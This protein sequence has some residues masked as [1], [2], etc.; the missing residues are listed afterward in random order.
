[1]SHELY[2][3][4]GWPNKD[5]GLKRSWEIHCHKK[6]T[7]ACLWHPQ[8]FSASWHSAPSWSDFAKNNAVL[9][10]WSSLSSNSTL[11]SFD[12]SAVFPLLSLGVFPFPLSGFRFPLFFLLYK[13]GSTSQAIGAASPAW[14]SLIKPYRIHLR[15]PPASPTHS[16]LRRSTCRGSDSPFELS[17]TEW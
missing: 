4:S 15:P 9:D 10:S 5:A 1:M 7:L 11:K 17:I 2:F 6:A 8:L 14:C 12:F 3:K 13:L 16:S